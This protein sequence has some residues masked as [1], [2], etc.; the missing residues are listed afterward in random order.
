[1]IERLRVQ[2]PAGA[3]GSFSSSEL[4]LCADSYLV[5]S[6]HCV[7]AVAHKTPWSFCQKGRWQITPE[8]AFIHDPTK[9]EWAGY[10]VQAQCGNSVVDLVWQFSFVLVAINMA[11]K[12]QQQQKNLHVTILLFGEQSAFSLCQSHVW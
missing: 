12:S 4:S 7:T 1:M 9:L 8:H 11:Q 6:P 2:V 5:S 10:V 3:A